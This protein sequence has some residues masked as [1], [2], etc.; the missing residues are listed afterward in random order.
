MITLIYS[1]LYGRKRTVVQL[2]W[3]K[4]KSLKQYLMDPAF[5][6]QDILNR[7][8]PFKLAGRQRLRVR[9]TWP[10]EKDS[11]IQLTG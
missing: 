3:T 6:Q 2:P 5:S 9:V 8:R 7:A 4:D 1:T 11:V 10:V